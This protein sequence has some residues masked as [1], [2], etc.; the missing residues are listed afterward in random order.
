MGGRM[1]LS[2]VY[3]AK[4]F[5]EAKSLCPKG[6]RMLKLSE[7]V[8][9]AEDKHEIIFDTE[10]GDWIFFWSSTLYKDISV[11]RL[12]RDGDG[13]W[14]AVWDDLAYSCEYGRV[15]FIKEEKAS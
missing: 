14:G 6:Y 3:K 11:R 5:K 1:K 15:F 9:L 4:T 2:K 10:Q 8:K 7:L 13:Y 12:G